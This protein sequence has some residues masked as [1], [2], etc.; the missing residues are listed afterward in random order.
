MRN[1]SPTFY[2]C[3]KCFLH[4]ADIA[5]PVFHLKKLIINNCANKLLSRY[6]G[7]RCV[8]EPLKPKPLNLKP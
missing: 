1:Y 5:L 6:S 7:N 4:Y 8:F 3:G 2:I